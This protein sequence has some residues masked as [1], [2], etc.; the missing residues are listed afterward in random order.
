M[1]KVNCV[2]REKI[3]PRNYRSFSYNSLT[4][5]IVR[6]GSHNMTVLYPNLCSGDINSSGPLVI[7]SEIERTS[8]SSQSTCHAGRML[9]SEGEAS[10]F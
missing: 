5:I 1:L 10:I 3:L 7:M 9:K 6:F 8:N 4:K 2:I